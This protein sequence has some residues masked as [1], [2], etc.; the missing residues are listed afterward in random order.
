MK[1]RD[2]MIHPVQ[3]CG[4]ET[5]LAAAAMMMWDGDCGV[6]PVVNFEGKVVG[7][8]TDRDICMA[9]ATKNRPASEITVFETITGQVHACRPDDDI[10]DAMETMAKHQVRRLPVLDDDRNLVGILS[11]NDI[12]LHA[13]EAKGRQAPAISADDV[14]RTL[15]AIDTHRILVGL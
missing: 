4:P 15:K 9:A 13:G 7:M 8:I 1:V 6:L 10:H 2:I 14:L 3:S 12:V 5:N 11:L